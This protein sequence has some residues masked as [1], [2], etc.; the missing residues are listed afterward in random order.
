[1]NEAT[2]SEGSDEEGDEKCANVSDTK[3]NRVKGK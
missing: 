3:Q 2:I 1:M